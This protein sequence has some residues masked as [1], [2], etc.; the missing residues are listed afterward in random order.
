MGFFVSAIIV[1]AG[2]P[3]MAISRTPTLDQL[4]QDGFLHH[5][6]GG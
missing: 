5:S 3:A 1:G 4:P 2:L 6:G